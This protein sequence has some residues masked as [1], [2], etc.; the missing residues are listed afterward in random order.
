MKFYAIYIGGAVKGSNVELHDMRFIIAD[1]I[2][3]TYPALKKEWWGI[4]K[5]LHLDAW[6]ELNHI[7]GYDIS[8]KHEKPAN[9]KNKLYFL[10]LGGYLKHEFSEVH[11]NIFVVAENEMDA[12]KKALGQVPEWQQAHKDFLYDVDDM[13]CLSN[14]AKEKGLYLH[15]KKSKEQKPFDFTCKYVPLYNK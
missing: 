6:A 11:R 4:P 7:D 3:D 8:L 12:K 14:I 10:N 9:E 15:I 5:S 13:H 1:N 2:T